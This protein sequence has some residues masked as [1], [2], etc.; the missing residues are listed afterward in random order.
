MKLKRETGHG[1]SDR[2]LEDEIVGL[3]AVLARY[4]EGKR[5]C[6]G[7]PS[8]CPDCGDFGMVER[9]DQ[10]EGRCEN[11]CVLCAREWT[12]SVRAMNE[13]VRRSADG[14]DPVR[15]RTGALFEALTAAG[16]EPPTPARPRSSP[17]SFWGRPA[18]IRPA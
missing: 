10:A 11:R 12:I 13:L 3:V 7:A 2:T 5:P 6:F 16:A 8:R 4:P 18:G 15:V 1:S 9:V 17:L 14:S